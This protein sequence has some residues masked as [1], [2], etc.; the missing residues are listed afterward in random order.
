MFINIVSAE[1]IIYDNI[2]TSNYK[3][4]KINDDINIKYLNEYKY[5]V[6]INGSYYG[7]F[8]KNEDIFIPDNSNITVYVPS[9]I[10]TDLTNQENTFK[11]VIQIVLSF[12]ISFILFIIVIYWLY[13][14]FRRWINYENKKYS[15][16]VCI[17]VKY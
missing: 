15:N 3:T 11:P 6:F 10:F 12:F 8:L 14:K 17:D 9:P 1:T 13:K 5:V 16:N 7:E 4:I 2:T